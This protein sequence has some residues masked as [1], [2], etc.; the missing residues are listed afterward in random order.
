VRGLLTWLGYWPER[1]KIVDR[2]DSDG[3]AVSSGA[4]HGVVAV[5]PSRNR[6]KKLLTEAEGFLELGLPE[7][8][9]NRLE[10]LSDEAARRS[11][12]LYLKGDALRRLHRYSE[13]LAPLSQAA[14]VAPSK[15]ETWLAL[16]AC[17]RRVGNLGA[18]IEALEKAREANAGDALIFFNLARYWSLS[19][20]KPHTLEH[21]AR[22][23]A[24]EPRFRERLETEPDFEPLRLDPDF[25]ALAKAPA[26]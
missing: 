10:R 25:Q 13:A 14:E 15:S 3:R 6:Q 21:L 9:L 7:H 16:G 26:V 23:L 19:G 8:A 24:L 1:S 11:S 5:D 4:G 20:D 2:E 18:A 12:A 17:Y 22:A